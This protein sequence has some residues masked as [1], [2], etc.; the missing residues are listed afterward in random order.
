MCARSPRPPSRVCARASCT[1]VYTQRVRARASVWSVHRRAC[2]LLVRRHKSV[3]PPVGDGGPPLL[4]TALFSS[5][6]P[7]V[8]EERV[9]LAMYEHTSKGR[10]TVDRLLDRLL[11]CALTVD[12]PR[13]A[14]RRLNVSAGRRLWKS[15]CLPR[16]AKAEEPPSLLPSPP[17]NRREGLPSSAS[18]NGRLI[19]QFLANRL[20]M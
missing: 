11:A 20:S 14:W 12:Y 13:L 9:R 7:L 15:E 6:T 5:P 4:P 2:S 18:R 1:R 17:E 8:R 16:N 3:L 10:S 19:A